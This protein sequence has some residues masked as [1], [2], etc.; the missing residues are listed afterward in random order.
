VWVKLDDG[1]PDNLKVGP[2]SDRAFR[3]HITALCFCGQQ[4]TD[5]QVP[6]WWIE[7]RGADPKELVDAELWTANAGGWE[8]HDFLVYNPSRAEVQGKREYALEMRALHKDR[9]LI[10]AIRRRDRDLCRFCAVQ[11]NWTDRRGSTGGTYDH[12]IPGAGNNLG[13]V[14]VSCRGCHSTKG[15]KALDDCELELM[16]P[17]PPPDSSR[18]QIGARTR[19]G[20]DQDTRP[21]PTR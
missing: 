15:G 1:M 2:L 9:S 13:N 14:V 16:A 7:R 6:T 11:V 17:P 12:L 20:S 10:E 18:S 19:P 21:D 5:G 4:L 8:I 3:L